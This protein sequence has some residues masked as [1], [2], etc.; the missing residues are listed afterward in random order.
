M[1]DLKKIKSELK[2]LINEIEKYTKNQ[3]KM[4]DNIE[5]IKK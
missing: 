5:K 4:L 2:Y 1:E 3:K